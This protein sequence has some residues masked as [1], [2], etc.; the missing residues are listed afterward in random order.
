MSNESPSKPSEPA[1]RPDET[2]SPGNGDAA[3]VDSTEP[4]EAQDT[5]ELRIA[6]IDSEPDASGLPDAVAYGDRYTIKRMLGRGGLGTVYAATDTV[7]QRVVALK[8]PHP[9]MVESAEQ[10]SRLWRRS[11]LVARVEHER[12]VRV[13]NIG[14]H[15]GFTFIAM[16]YV[17]GDTLR[18]WMS[19]RAA[20][21]V[22]WRQVVDIA[23]QIAEGLAELH[24]HG[25]V[26]RDLKPGTVM[27][28][29]QGAVKLIGLQLAWHPAIAE[30]AGT[31]CGTPRYMAPEQWEGNDRVDAR[32]DVFALGLIMY[33]LVTGDSP[34]NGLDLRETMTASKNGVPLTGGAWARVPRRLRSHIS[35]MLAVDPEQRFASGIE[36]LAVLREL[37]PDSKGA[38]KHRVNAVLSPR[39]RRPAAQAPERARSTAL[40]R[41]VLFR[42]LLSRIFLL[43]VLTIVASLW[44]ITRAAVVVP[45][46]TAG[47]I[48]V[49]G[50]QM[51]AGVA[52]GLSGEDSDEYNT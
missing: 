34:F 20:R 44:W 49:F 48:V 22:P 37:T 9:H 50:E 52:E 7:L 15:G 2:V 42:N 6:D 23:T 33:E 14:T 19:A 10:S 3:A 24:D 11:Q 8:I 4:F 47:I 51:A 18:E 36:V 35:R 43:S 28:T 40:R 25:I 12:V 27:L 21:E 29:P 5:A 39:L 1:V 38:L 30:P 41:K 13:Y 45:L 31:V 17:P 26:H 46:F 32:I 16:E